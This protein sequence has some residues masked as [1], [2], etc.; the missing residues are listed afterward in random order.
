MQA[1]TIPENVF[2]LNQCIGWWCCQNCKKRRL[3]LCQIRAVVVATLDDLMNEECG[4][5]KKASVELAKQ[6]NGKQERSG[7]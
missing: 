7:V 5:S 6:M 3:H 1:I 4:R 2:Q